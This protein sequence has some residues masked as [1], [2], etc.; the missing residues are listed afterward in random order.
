MTLSSIAARPSRRRTADTSGTGKRERSRL[1]TLLWTFP[2]TYPGAEHPK[3]GDGMPSLMTICLMG[4]VFFEGHSDATTSSTRKVIASLS[5]SLQ[6][7]ERHP[8]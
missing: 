2:L 5:L 7:E 1:G 3:L 4:D 8:I 6:E